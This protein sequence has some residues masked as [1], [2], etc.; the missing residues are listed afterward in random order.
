MNESA[1]IYK[2]VD[3]NFLTTASFQRDGPYVIF[4]ELYLII[5]SLLNRLNKSAENFS[6]E[7][8]VSKMS[9][10]FCPVKEYDLWTQNFLMEH[11]KI[12]GFCGKKFIKFEGNRTV[13]NLLGF[14]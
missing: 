4:P 11:Q 7:D 13:N 6:I 3:L 9:A 2:G 14:F 5:Q 12:N 8:D 1:Q 10:T